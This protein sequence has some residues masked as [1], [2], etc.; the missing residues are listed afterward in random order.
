[1]VMYIALATGWAWSWLLR[2]PRNQPI[3]H[4]DLEHAHWDPDSRQWF[5]H[6]DLHE[7]TPAR[8]A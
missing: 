8:A 6:A 1:M 4:R 5:I 2:R 3:S 7:V